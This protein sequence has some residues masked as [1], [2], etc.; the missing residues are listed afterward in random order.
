[1]MSTGELWTILRSI[2]RAGLRYVRDRAGHGVE[3]VRSAGSCWVGDTYTR[4]ELDTLPGMAPRLAEM[5]PAI[6]QALGVPSVAIDE[7]DGRV[8]VTV[9]HATEGDELGVREAQPRQRLFGCSRDCE[10][11]RVVFAPPC[12]STC[13]HQHGTD[14]R[15]L[16]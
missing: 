2:Q 14:E 4:Y 12:T 5:A 9:T 11:H 15:S 13:Q 6:A 16:R 10:D 8:F 7:Q 1:M 3:A